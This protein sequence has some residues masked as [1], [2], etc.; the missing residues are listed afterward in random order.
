[1]LK[2]NLLV[3]EYG[4]IRRITAYLHYLPQSDWLFLLLTRAP[5]GVHIGHD[6]NKP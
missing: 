5:N 1:M 2:I 3:F 6:R 4:I